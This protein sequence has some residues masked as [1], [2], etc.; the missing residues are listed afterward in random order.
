[1]QEENLYFN[2][3]TERGRGG[4]RIKRIKLLWSLKPKKT[5][6]FLSASPSQRLSVK[7]LFGLFAFDRV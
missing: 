7:M 5:L 4:E 1:L 2:A 3:E 6:D